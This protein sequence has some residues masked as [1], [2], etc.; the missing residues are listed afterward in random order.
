MN[1]LGT[2]IAL[3]ALVIL[4]AGNAAANDNIWFGV[5]AGTLGFGAEAAWRPIDWFDV[6]AGANFFDYDDTGAQAGINYDAT[7][8]LDT[9]YLTGNFRFP[10]SPF[11]M[12]VGAFSNG[13]EVR[14][15]STD[16]TAYL[17][18]NND[19]P[20]SAA[21]IG[22]LQATTSFD[23]FAPYLGAG[24]DFEVLDRLGLSLDFG[25]LWQGDPSVS[26]TASGLLGTDAALLADLEIERQ[27]LEDDLGDLKAY[28]VVSVGFHFNFR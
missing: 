13:N 6:R 7:L 18:G 16:A 15:V 27:Q 8:A 2:R 12:T 4:G 10:L 9:Y 21:D 22:T 26:L 20:Y 11:R 19:I 25:V 3:A 23:D 1:T 5:K 17:I 24:F 28:P 14:M